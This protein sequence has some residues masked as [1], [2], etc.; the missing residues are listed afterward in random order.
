MRSSFAL[1]HYM[2]SRLGQIRPNVRLIQSAGMIYPEELIG[3]NGQDVCIAFLF[4]RY[5]KTAANLILWLRKRGVR[6]ILF[7]SQN[8]SAIRTYGDIFLPCSVRGVS[9]KNSFAAPICLINYISAAIALLDRS[10]AIET[11]QQ[12]EEF[13]NKGYHLGL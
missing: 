3:C 5:S 8:Y 10:R 7:T 9:F 12:T 2:T 4:P 11:L 13:L 6:I 1:A